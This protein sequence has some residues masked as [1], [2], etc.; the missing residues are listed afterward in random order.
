MRA[1][2]LLTH[3]GTWVLLAS[4]LTQTAFGQGG[5]ASQLSGLVTDPTGAVVVGAQITVRNAETG[6]SQST[7]TSREGHY[8]LANLPPGFYE[9]VIAA[10]GFVRL[11]Q[12]RVRRRRRKPCASSASSPAATLPTSDRRLEQ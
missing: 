12:I 6:L 10:P 7:Q 11:R 1:A 8:V 5:A 3:F 2:H 4:T 9:V